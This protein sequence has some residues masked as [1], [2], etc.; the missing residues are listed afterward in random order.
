VLKCC[1]K[2]L[3]INPRETQAWILKGAGLCSLDQFRDAL[4]CFEKA[5]VL[6]DSS[7][8]HHLKNCRK[9]YA[10]W[11]FRLASRYQQEGNHAEA[12]S[13]YEKG[14]AMDSSSAVA[15][16]NKGAALLELGRAA[17]AVNCCDRAIDLD[18]ENAG[19]WNNK[20]VALMTL[21]QREEGAACILKARQMG[22]AKT[23]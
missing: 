20:G 14:I 2:V 5:A 4:S 10:A 9:E 3:E 19:A 7:A 1:D 16:V 11:Y 21:G 13:C 17:D 23:E 8:A 12:N 15:W 6:G 22:E 18:S